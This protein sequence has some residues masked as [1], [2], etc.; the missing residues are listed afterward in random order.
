MW[1][2]FF[3]IGTTA[4]MGLGLP[5]W[6]SPFHFGFFPNLRQ[7]VGLLGR[8][9]SSSQGW[10]TL[11]LTYWDCVSQCGDHEDY[12]PQGRYLLQDS[13]V[14]RGGYRKLD[15]LLFVYVS[16]ILQ[17]VTTTQAFENLKL[18]VWVKAYSDICHEEISCRFSEESKLFT[19]LH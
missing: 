4:P 15:H 17:T 10:A 2:T 1:A 11:P 7:S 6:N 18:I 3:F 19:S 14:V 8:V 13:K 5:P 16:T 9:I 12:G